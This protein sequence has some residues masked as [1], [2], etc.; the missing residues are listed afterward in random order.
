MRDDANGKCEIWPCKELASRMKAEAAAIA[1]ASGNPNKILEVI[2]VGD[3]PAS[4][5]YVKGKIKDCEE[6]GFRSVH[7]KMGESATTQD[8]IDAIKHSTADGIIVQLP[9]PDHINKDAV[10]DAIPADRDVD[11][12]LPVNLGDMMLGN[13]KGFAPCTPAGVMRLLHDKGV[14]L[15]GCDAVVIGRSDIVG[16]PMTVLLINEGA[17]VTCCNSKTKDLARY[18]SE[19]DLII[20]AA[21]CHGILTNDNVKKGAIII[22]VSINR[23]DDGNLCGDA[24]DSVLDVAGAITPVPGGIGLLTRA[25]LMINLAKTA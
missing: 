11:G 7:T 20:S 16:K 25:Q 18:T 10:N 24:D 1:A 5:V 4:A 21:G 22:D 19:A 3:D 9:L 15:H 13:H 17:T 23:S 6:C 12:F 8:V 14:E 2:T